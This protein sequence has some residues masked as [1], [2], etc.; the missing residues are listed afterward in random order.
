MCVYVCI[1]IYI[2]ICLSVYILLMYTSIM[3]FHGFMMAS[4]LFRSWKKI[5]IEVFE[6]G[7][8]LCIL[9]KQTPHR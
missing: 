9:L 5:L 6:V 8:L 3:F 4:N 2:Y 1:F 7:H